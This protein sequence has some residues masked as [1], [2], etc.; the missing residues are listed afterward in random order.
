MAT[1]ALV[2]FSGGLDSRLALRIMKD[3]LGEKNI[4]S[5]FFLL[6]FGSGCCNEHCALN[7]SQKELTKLT[8]ID[9][10]KGK[11]LQEYIEIIKNPKHGTGAAM[12]PCKDCKIFMLKKAKAYADKNKIELI[13]TGEVL[14]ERPMSQTK[15]ALNIIEEETGL[16]GRLLRPLSAKL[17]P[18]TIAEKEGRIDREKFFAL[19]GRQRKKQI[20][21]ANKYQITY[22]SPAGGCLL[23][24]KDFCKKLKPLLKGKLE[25]IDVPLLKLG[26][27]FE[28]S[29][30]ILG[31]NHAENEKLAQLKET[32]KQGIII[33][34]RQPGPTAF[35]KDKKH[36]E[37]AKELIKKHSKH[38]IKE[39]KVKE[40]SF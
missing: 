26:R 16:K 34:P 17:L 24:E 7:F 10:T 39:F 9:C 4:E 31:R 35:I 8:V 27:H 14:N 23:C 19:H 33:I 21:L 1:K 32:F 15:K 11:L 6:P 5:I 30:I 28:T 25:E 3:L 36:F 29:S 20:E 18:E 2:L 37:K 13:A 22:P 40:E 38:D 12:N